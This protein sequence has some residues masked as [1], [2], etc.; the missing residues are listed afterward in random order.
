MSGNTVGNP[1]G[2]FFFFI[3]PTRDCNNFTVFILHAQ[4]SRGFTVRPSAWFIP[5]NIIEYHTVSTYSRLFVSDAYFLQPRALFYCWP[6][7]DFRSRYAAMAALWIFPTWLH[8]RQ[9]DLTIFHPYAF[10]M[11]PL[12]SKKKF[13]KHML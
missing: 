12:L 7:A 9:P 2:L 4:S 5:Y 3:F 1:K 11:L 13:P 6:R 8:A 10:F